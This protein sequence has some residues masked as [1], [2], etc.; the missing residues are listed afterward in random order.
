MSYTYPTYAGSA[1]CAL[2]GCAKY[3]AAV[4]R[5]PLWP[6]AQLPRLP[7][8]YSDGAARPAAWWRR[9]GTREHAVLRPGT[10]RPPSRPDQLRGGRCPRMFGSTGSTRCGCDGV[11]AAPPV[12]LRRPRQGAQARLLQPSLGELCSRRITCRA[13]CRPGA[14]PQLGTPSLP[15]PEPP[16][17]PRGPCPGPRRTHCHRHP[18]TAEALVAMMAGILLL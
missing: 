5:W 10:A 13:R 16:L 6:P 17:R 18:A 15:G 7:E 4:A 8:L 1:S 9:R 11:P 3:R 14:L 2:H 12:V